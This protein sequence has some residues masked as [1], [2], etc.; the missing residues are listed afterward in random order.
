[1]TIFT[2]YF[3]ASGHPDGLD[4]LAVAGFIAE[5]NQWIE[6][7]RNWKEIL[8]RQD[9][10]VSSLHMKDFC[11]S[12]GEFA[13]WKGDE[14]RRRNFLSALI[15]TIKVRARHSFANSIYLPDYRALDQKYE[16]SDNYPPLAYSGGNC[17]GHVHQWAQKWGIPQSDIA[18][19]F[20]DG[21]KDRGKLASQ[22]Q[23][24]YGINVNFLKKAQN[25]AF[26]AADLLAYEH[27]NANR[28][29][30][31]NPGVFALNELRNPLQKLNEIPNG[32][33][34]EDWSVTERPQLERFCLEQ[35]IPLR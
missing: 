2:A 22:A 23:S 8:N 4:V 9:F 12:T 27:F 30:M 35:K 7:E 5:V 20:E 26:Q 21:D 34:G 18:Y 15:G 17:I 25:V 31:P 29:V 24:V 10:K 28:R 19:C 33:N 16:L 1:M 32:D 14:Q 11:H 13:S 3:D 6:F